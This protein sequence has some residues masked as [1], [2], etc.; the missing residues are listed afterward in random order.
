MRFLT[1]FSIAGLLACSQPAAAP[2]TGSEAPGDPTPALRIGDE[3]VSLGE[4]DAWIKEQLFQQETRNGE[5][6]KLYEVRAQGADNF[7][8]QRLLEAE[9][10]KLGVSAEELLETEARK[11]ME[12]PDDE[13]ERFYEEHKKSFGERPIDEV[14]T[15][16]REHL[17]RRRAPEAAREYVDTLREAAQVTMLLERPRTPVEAIGPARGPADAP[18]TIVE[19]SDYQC[20]FCRR[21]EP[22]LEQV[23]ERYEGK[24]RFVFR[25]FPLDRIHP[26]AR[27][28]SEAAACADKQGKFW[29]YHAALFAENAQLDRP[30]LDAL[31]EQLGLDTAAFASCLEDDATK[32]LVEKDLQAGTAAGVTGTPA[33]FINGIPLRGAVPAADFERIIDQELAERGA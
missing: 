13:V 16:V 27:G 33:F 8:S 31:A 11:R 1:M 14:K 9:A 24:I 23:L 22:T 15:Q 6:A 17:E 29:E 10:Q 7:V 20:P 2:E 18:V 32:Q 21:A 19:F 4:L 30:G 12:V 25:H 26:Q 3:S 28:A 5:E